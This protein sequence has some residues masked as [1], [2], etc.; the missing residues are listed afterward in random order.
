MTEEAVPGVPSLAQAVE[1][2]A[3]GLNEAPQRPAQESV[4]AGCE[5]LLGRLV[6]V[7][8][9]VLAVD[10]D[11]QPLTGEP[12]RSDEIALARVTLSLPFLAERTGDA[13][14]DLLLGYDFV[15]HRSNDAFYNYSS[16]AASFTVLASWGPG[17]GF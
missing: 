17:R 9:A 13:D 1:E 7:G 5:E 15:R 11:G 2:R 3:V 12:L 6:D 14:L 16:H 8:Q 10:L 4:G